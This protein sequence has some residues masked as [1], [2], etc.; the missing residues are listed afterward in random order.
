MGFGRR[1]LGFNAHLSPFLHRNTIPYP[2]AVS[3]LS[4]KNAR[5]TEG[6]K[7]EEER[8]TLRERWGRERGKGEVQGKGGK[9]EEE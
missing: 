6:E 9:D 8:G 7:K 2:G 4:L 3:K 1:K 5:R